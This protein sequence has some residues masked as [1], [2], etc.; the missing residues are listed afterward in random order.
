MKKLV[1]M[2]MVFMATTQTLPLHAASYEYPYLTFVTNSGETTVS[3]A[4]LKM[5]IQG[6]T[7][8]VT[9]AEGT[10]TLNL[11]ELNKMYFSSS[12]TGIGN[13]S[14]KGD[15]ATEVFAL[16][17]TLMGKYVSKAAAMKVLKKGEYVLK[18]KAQT[19]KV[20]VK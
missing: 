8:T 9:N 1:L 13:V 12:T 18:S 2:L 14:S 4:S 16:D 5:T 15:E 10:S 3:V 11:T 19:I 17:G 6:N 20:A 7:L